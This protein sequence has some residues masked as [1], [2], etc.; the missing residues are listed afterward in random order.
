MIDSS[1]GFDVPASEDAGIL[2]REKLE[3]RKALIHKAWKR[4]VFAVTVSILMGLTVLGLLGYKLYQERVTTYNVDWKH[5]GFKDKN[6]EI[7]GSRKYSYPSITIAGF[8]FNDMKDVEEKTFLKTKGERVRVL[9]LSQDDGPKIETIGTGDVG[10][11]HPIPKAEQYV[12]IYDKDVAVVKYAD[13][14]Q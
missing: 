8:R 2:S 5:C 3:R 14:C 1:R 13:F 4:F 9:G 12:F 10:D 11:K 6:F 7:E